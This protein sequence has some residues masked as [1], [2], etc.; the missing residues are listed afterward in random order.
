MN[1][2]KNN[3]KTE[4]VRFGFFIAFCLVLTACNQEAKETNK[5]KEIVSKSVDAHG[6]IEAWNS[7]KTLSF[8]KTTMLFLEDGSIER[9]IDQHQTFH[10][11]EVL[12]GSIRDLNADGNVGYNYDNGKYTRVLNDSILPVTEQSEIDALNYSF[13]AAHYVI[14]QPFGLLSDNA[15]L[16]YGGEVTHE[17]RPCYIVN[18]SYK[19]DGEE[20]DQWSYI[21]DA[22]TY[23]L[24][25]NKVKL[26]DHTSWI[27]NL[28]YDTST[29]IK[30][31]AERKSYRL[32]D[33]DEKL[34]LRAE[35][36][37]SNYSI[38]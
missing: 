3:I 8:K 17:D 20:A 5:A 18:V 10:F 7:I 37:Y 11:G 34:Y 29:N 33:N 30:F 12:K 28:S 16:T 1:N 23:D 35:Y 6:G 4:A 22:Q 2:F 9:R 24:V 38:E 21:F 27:E 32:G 26:S 19:T 13:F 15:V 36:F 14:C 25:A 31:N